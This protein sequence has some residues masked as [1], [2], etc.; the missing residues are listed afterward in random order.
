M[1]KTYLAEQFIGRL[2]RGAAALCSKVPPTHTPPLLPI[3]QALASNS[4]RPIAEA[5]SLAVKKYSKAAPILKETLAPMLKPGANRRLGGAAIQNITPPETHTFFA[6][7]DILLHV[8]V[9]RRTVL[10]IDDVQWLDDSSTAF[11]GYLCEEL[12]RVPIFL[13]LSARSNGMEPA[14]VSSLRMALSRAGGQI[15]TDYHLAPLST[16]EAIRVA[17]TSLRGALHCT[18]EEAEWLRRASKGIPKYL[19]EV[20]TRLR[21]QGHLELSQGV[22]RF[23]KPPEDLCLQSLFDMTLERL[24]SVVKDQPDTELIIQYAAVCGVRFDARV[25]ASI[26]G[27]ILKNRSEDVL[28][29]VKSCLERVARET[30]FVK[31]L[32]RTTEWTFDHDITREAILADLGDFVRDMH[33]RVADVLAQNKD[34]HPGLVAYHYR[35]ARAWRLAAEH[36]GKA[37]QGAARCFTFEDAAAAAEQQEQMLAHEGCPVESPERL[38]SAELLARCLIGAQRYEQATVLLSPLH[39]AGL[40][41]DRPILL[42]WLAQAKLNLLDAKS[43]EEATKILSA[44]TRRFSAAGDAAAAVRLGTELVLAYEAVSNH[45]SSQATFVRAFRHAEET[46][47]PLWRTRLRRLTC[48]FFQPEKVIDCTEEALKLA[49]GH[50]LHFEEALC[51]NNLGTQYWYL[52]DLDRARECFERSLHVL[53][54]SCGGY[55]RDL[56]INNLG[57]I[58]LVEERSEEALSMFRKALDNSLPLDDRLFISANEAVALA[59]LGHIDAAIGVLSETAKKADDAGDVFYRDCVRYNLARSLLLRGD[60]DEAIR[61]L[62]ACPP[63]CW[64]TDDALVL[65][66]RASLLLD[67]CACLGRE[68]DPDWERQRAVL[69][70]TKKPQVW[71]YKLP[72]ELCDIQFWQS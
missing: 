46:G 65:A 39:K 41:E 68:P 48:I 37:A 8:G 16:E 35:E 67:A 59:K 3:C 47:D 61:A 56:P 12:N 44:A 18:A 7:S 55:R 69:D 57:L 42:H 50:G 20:V 49:R 26:V 43:H 64:L 21:E 34:I 60:A 53:L 70:Q 31:R 17:E 33:R 14:R 27:P 15:F 13:L 28:P 66:K 52:R 29:Y 10:F 5:I 30:A 36:F 19:M 22:W 4:R 45:Q 62:T 71:L 1:G 54:S 11:L 9:Q 38:Q 32:G 24:E 51:L 6:L 2:P 25:I 63:R 23:V 72:W 58:S 40:L